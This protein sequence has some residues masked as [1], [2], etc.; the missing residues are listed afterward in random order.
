MELRGRGD[1]EGW[2]GGRGWRAGGWAEAVGGEV[3]CGVVILGVRILYY[4]QPAM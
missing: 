1:D 3:R 2:D 4:G